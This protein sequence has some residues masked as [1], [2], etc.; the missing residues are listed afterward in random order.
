MADELEEIIRAGSKSF[1]LASRLLPKRVRGATLALY[2]FCRDA[3]DRV[4]GAD[5]PRDAHR[6]VDALEERLDQVY[7]A[8]KLDTLVLRAFSQVVERFAIP[9]EIPRALVD[10]MRWDAQGKVYR[11]LDDVL[12]YGV[13]VAGTVGVMMTLIMGRRDPNVLARACDLGVAMQ[14][15]NIARDVGEDARMGRV[16]LPSSWLRELSIDPAA[17]LAAP[18]ASDGTRRATQR[19][20][21]EAERLYLRADDGV[22]HLP[23]DCRMSIRAARLVYSDIGKEIR[24]ADHDSVSRRAVVPLPRK[25][26]LLMRAFGAR[27]QTPRPLLDGP[28]RESRV[29]VDAVAEAA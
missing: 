18:R 22:P 2:A 10:G 26:W 9:K 28:R 14:L 15:T 23:A 29:L 16:Y 24:A 4:D 11:E 6:A 5:A 12:D 7:A 19:L 25:L 8:R 20:L 21:E 17:F 3:D 13:R 1:H 27:L